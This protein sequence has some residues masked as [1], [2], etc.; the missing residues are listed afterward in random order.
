MIDIFK[1]LL[2]L[3]VRTCVIFTVLPVKA[4]LVSVT[5]MA[6]ICLPTFSKIIV[7]ICDDCFY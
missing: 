6:S 7:K 2:T 5:V 3:F 1:S 4:I